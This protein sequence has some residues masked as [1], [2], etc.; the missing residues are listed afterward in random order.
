MSRPLTAHVWG[1]VQFGGM[2]SS[3]ACSVRGHVPF[4]ALFA[5][6]AH[7]L[8]VC[9]PIL[10]IGGSGPS[11][12]CRCAT[13]RRIC[14][15]W[16]CG[17]WICGRSCGWIRSCPRG[18][19]WRGAGILRFWQRH[20]I[21][22]ERVEIGDHVGALLIVRQTS[23]GHRGARRKRARFNQPSVECGEI[24]GA[25]FRFQG[26]RIIKARRGG[27]LAPD[28]GV[29]IRPDLRSLALLEVVAGLAL[30]CHICAALSRRACQ[31][32]FDRH[33]RRRRRS[34]GALR[35]LLLFDRYLIA[36]LG[37]RL[38]GKN[39][40]GRNAH[41]DK[42]KAGAQQGAE[43]LIEFKRIHWLIAPQAGAVVRRCWAAH[44]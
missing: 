16:I 42:N 39:G 22:R 41:G 23:K 21:G 18:R 3:G 35:R 15:R 37:W 27:D 33:R 12:V 2:F 36:G 8:W 25:I 9:Q 17:R 38:R 44:K 20:R 40:S 7:R 6:F 11:R 31:Q 43:D 13:G 28:Y 30:P 26:G 5:A 24:P 32:V 14:G 10:M 19:G 1:H 29:E 4:G 34:R